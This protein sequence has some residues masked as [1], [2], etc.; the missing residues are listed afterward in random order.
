MSKSSTPD[1][2][3]L[4]NEVR[5]LD[6]STPCITL[7]TNASWKLRTDPRHLL[8][9]FARYK[10]AAR[11]LPH[12]PDKTVLEL[13]CGEGLGTLFLAETAARV[14]A[15]DFDAFALEQARTHYATEKVEYRCADFLGSFFGAFQGIVS[16]DVIE[17]IDAA[18]EGAYCKT[19]VDNLAHGGVCVVGTPNESASPYASEGSKIGHIN[20]YTAERLY[21]AMRRWFCNVFLLGINDEML[22]TGFHPMCHYLLAVACNPCR[23][24]DS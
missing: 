14:L 3:Q 12:E 1:A 7:G 16:L 17:H 24:S 18:Q 10:H 13:G 11:L 15:V 2:L 23:R 8:F 4:W 21:A 19:L 9:T 6:R 22:H 5:D 20:M